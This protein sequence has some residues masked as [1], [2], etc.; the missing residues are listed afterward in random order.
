MDFWGKLLGGAAGFALG[1]PLGALLGTAAG[2]AY[3]RFLADQ[4]LVAEREPSL[5]KQTAFAVAVIVLCAKMAKADGHVSRGEIAA[6]KD[7]F[8]VPPEEERNVSRLFD[9]ARRDARGFEPYARQVARMFRDS[10]AVLEQL[11]GGLFHIARADGV[12]HPDAI[13]YLRSVATILGFDDERFDRIRIA[14]MGADP[15]DPYRMLGVARGASDA[16]VRNAWLGLL[17]EC[18]PDTLI[19]QG[20]PPDFLRVATQRAAAINAAW[21]RIREQ[22]GI[23]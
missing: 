19:A 2:H 12:A 11:L 5:A 1:G 14:H 18:H 4:T 3:D 7:V 22:R 9:L 21:D 13:A 17:R 15:E 10:P 6:F 8:H 23:A 20:M 16:E